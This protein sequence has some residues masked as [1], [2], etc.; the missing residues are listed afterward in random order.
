MH[1]HTRRAVEGVMKSRERPSE[2]LFR[3]RGGDNFVRERASAKRSFYVLIC[4]KPFKRLA[5]LSLS[6]SVLAGESRE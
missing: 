4:I 6:L 1:R 5:Y 3:R 2:Y